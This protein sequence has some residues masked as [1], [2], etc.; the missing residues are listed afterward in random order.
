MKVIGVIEYIILLVMMWN[1]IKIKINI[2][3]FNT[4]YEIYPLKRLFSKKKT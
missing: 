4:S 3:N 2:G 1:G